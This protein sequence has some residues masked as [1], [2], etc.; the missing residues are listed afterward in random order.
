MIWVSLFFGNRALHEK[1]D[2]KG[3]GRLQFFA[4]AAVC[5]FAWYLLPGY[6]FL[7]I[8]SLSWICWTWK[9]SILAHQLGSGM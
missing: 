1:E 5:S 9:D 7:T 6:M 3:V 4:I 8:T 2:S